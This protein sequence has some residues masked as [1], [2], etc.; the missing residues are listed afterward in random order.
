MASWGIPTMAAGRREWDDLTP[1]QATQLLRTGKPLSMA[2]KA[3]DTL[4]QGVFDNGLDNRMNNGD[5]VEFLADV[6]ADIAYLDPP[7]PGT[8]AY[9]QV[10]AG[11]NHLLDPSMPT[12]P[13]DWSAADGWRL[14]KQAFEAAE[15]VPLVVISMGKGADPEE[16]SEM[17]TEAGRE[18]SWKSLDHKHLSALKVDHDPDGDE[19]LLM[20]VKR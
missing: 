15:N 7:Y 8:L 19:L 14:L 16:I 2:V 11:V 20:G 18:P 17:M 6:E 3:A 4:N 5:A 13:S 9:E 12:D 10:Y 1:G